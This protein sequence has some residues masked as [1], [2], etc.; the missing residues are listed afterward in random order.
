ML[1]APLN[2]WQL[3]TRVIRAL[4]DSALRPVEHV[5]KYGHTQTCQQ[6]N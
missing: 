1:W 4:A 2:D 3:A 5:K 6:M